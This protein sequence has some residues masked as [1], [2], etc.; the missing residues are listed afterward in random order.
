L[1]FARKLFREAVPRWGR[2][3]LSVRRD[4]QDAGQITAQGDLELA[5][6]GRQRDLVHERPNDLGGFGSALF[7]IQSLV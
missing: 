5:I 6:L 7:S 3:P 1:R 4:R 2:R